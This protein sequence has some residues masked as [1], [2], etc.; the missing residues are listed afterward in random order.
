MGLFDFMKKKTAA[1][2]EDKTVSAT[3]T[4][5]E[6]N[7][8]TV[9]EAPVESKEQAQERAFNAGTEAYNQNNYHAAVTYWIEAARLGS[10]TAMGNLRALHANEKL[11]IYNPEVAF[12]WA[13]KAA[14]LGDAESQFYCARIYESSMG[15]FADKTKAVYWYEKSAEQGIAAAQFNCGLMYA[16]GEGISIDKAKALYWLEKAAEQGVV[17]AQALCGFMYYGGE[18][19]AI[20]YAKA[21]YWLVKAADQGHEQ[22]KNILAELQ[23]MNEQKN[24]AQQ[25]ASA[26]VVAREE[27][28]DAELAEEFFQKYK[29]LAEEDSV[30]AFEYLQKAANLWH[31]EA[32]NDVMGLYRSGVC[33]EFLLSPVLEEAAER[34]KNPEKAVAYGLEAEKHGIDVAWELM[35]AYIE[36]ENYEQAFYW[37]KIHD[38]RHGQTEAVER[39]E[40]EAQKILAEGVKCC[41]QNAYQQ[42]LVFFEKAAEQGYAKAQKIC[43]ERYMYGDGVLPDADKALYWFKE[44]IKAGEDETVTENIS[45]L[46][47][48]IDDINNVKNGTSKIDRMISNY[49]NLSAAERDELINS[50]HSMTNRQ[51]AAYHYS[52]AVELAKGIDVLV[53]EDKEFVRSYIKRLIK[54]CF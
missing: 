37:A 17:N 24:I 28:P 9:E 45:V 36:T 7:T 18:G 29:Y 11:D 51:N 52:I 8:T 42:A 35:Y 44:A 38:S 33:M 21:R 50:L 26:K 32:V 27:K 31:K 39:L 13:L 47:Q 48:L 15:V 2:S 4:T 3:D 34:W 43:A 12:Q 41:N 23:K 22:S 53:D 19:T 14:E 40:E 5:K 10:L 1:V 20:D 46:E 25:A 6:Q 54:K 49:S 16:K 30:E